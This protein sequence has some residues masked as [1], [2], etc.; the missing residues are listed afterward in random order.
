[1]NQSRIAKTL[2]RTAIVSWRDQPTQYDIEALRA[3]LERVGLVIRVRWVIV[4]T[5]AMFSVVAALVYGSSVA[6]D[7]L[8]RNMTIPVIA[9]LFVLMYNGFYK[10][11]LRKAGNVAFLNQGQLIFDI[12]VTTVLVY[13]SGGVYSWFSSMYLLFILEGAFILPKRHHVWLLVCASAFFYGLVLG[14]EYWGW[15]PHVAMPFVD[16]ALFSNSTYVLVRYLWKVTLYAGTGMIGML[17]MKRIHAREQELRESSFVDETTGLYNRQY[18]H[19]VLNAEA[20]RARRDRGSL[21]LILADIYQ[22][23]EFNRVFGME[24]GDEILSAIADEIKDVLHEGRTED[25]YEV[26]VACRVGGEEL[27]IIVPEAFRHNDDADQ[28]QDHVRALAERV[29][30]RV[31]NFRLRGLGVTLSLGV[32]VAPDNGESASCLLD[33]A[34]NA[35]YAASEAGGNQVAVAWEI[36]A[37]GLEGRV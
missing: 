34:D 9:L 18:F 23:G 4:A 12:I 19:R 22:F 21:G 33:A 14:A 15:I 20:D 1:M 36:D 7:Q 8:V 32:A 16:N 26:N 25:G 30:E 13:Y 28:A 11:T 3:N 27:A 31:E 24:V 37:E 6:F 17:M 2:A 35:L 5:L 10:I 29:R